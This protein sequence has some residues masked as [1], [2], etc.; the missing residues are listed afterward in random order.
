[1]IAA[2]ALVAWGLVAAVGSCTTTH[3]DARSVIEGVDRF[4]R[5]ENAQKPEL[6]DA[7]AKLPCA[8]SEVCATKDACVSSAAST[9]RG[10]RLQKEVE[11]TL[12]QVKKGTLP[13]SDPKATSLGAKLDDA[14][15][16]L[17]QGNQAL[18][19]CDQKL[20]RLRVKYH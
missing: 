2:R 9:A 13:A 6:A 18:V 12:A 14:D 20:T 17:A 16:A 1:M 19:D 8:D 5:A 15:R 10:L 11:D 4:R 7:L 3:Q